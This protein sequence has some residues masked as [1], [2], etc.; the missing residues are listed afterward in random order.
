MHDEVQPAVNE[1]GRRCPGFADLHPHQEDDGAQGALELMWR[2]QEMLA[3]VV[4]L[5][6]VTLQPAAGAQGE[7]TGLMLMRAYFADRGED[8]DRGA[9]PRLGAWHKP[10]LWR[11]PVHVRAR[12]DRRAAT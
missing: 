3:E 6:A 7:L 12:E 10:R 5:D 2:L 1:R 9:H 4:G 11:W 8:R